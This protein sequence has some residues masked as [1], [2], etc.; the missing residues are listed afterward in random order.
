M[1]RVDQQDPPL[2]GDE[3]EMEIFDGNC[4]APRWHVPD[5][6]LAPTNG[7]KRRS[8]P[9][10]HNIAS[11]HAG[12]ES[13]E[14]HGTQTPPLHP[15]G[16]LAGVHDPIGERNCHVGLQEANVE[17]RVNFDGTWQYQT[18]R[19]GPDLL[20]NLKRTSSPNIKLGEGRHIM[21]M[22]RRNNQTFWPTTKFGA[23]RRR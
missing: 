18:K 8:R 11:F 20:Q 19:R 2:K 6:Q 22:W 23:A 1:K 12:N 17:H 4:E 21:V 16:V 9:N 3:D 7:P 5:F 13:P 14:S 10:P 15:F